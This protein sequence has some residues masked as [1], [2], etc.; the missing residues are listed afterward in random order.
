MFVKAKS[1]AL[2][3]HVA[4]ITVHVYAVDSLRNTREELKRQS[5]LTHFEGFFRPETAKY[6]E[7]KY[8]G[9]KSDS[10]NRG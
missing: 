2:I 3:F 8:V 5:Q 9:F 7:A 6:K 1:Q 4:K 10:R